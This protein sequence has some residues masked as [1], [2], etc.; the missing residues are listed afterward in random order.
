MVTIADK[1]ATVVRGA[2]LLALALVFQGLRLLFPLPPLL[3]MF[4]IGSLVN[5]TLILAI[6]HAG[7]LPALLMSALLPIAAFMQG[8]LA[9]PLLIPVVI[10][11]NIA[12]VLLCHIGRSHYFIWCAPLGKVLVLY[13]G[14][15]FILRYFAISP[16]V[17]E[18][19]L[20]A[21]GWPQIVTAGIGLGMALWL[22]RRLPLASVR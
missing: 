9:L 13:V 6:W 2:L 5:L 11:G 21:M 7:L 12:F 20:L 15:S 1:K 18:V 8:Q 16:Q 19:L 4:L 22:S 3:G 17:A 10:V 14:A